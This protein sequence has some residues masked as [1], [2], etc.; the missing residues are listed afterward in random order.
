M[1][2]CCCFFCLLVCVLFLLLP[3]DRSQ[4]RTLSAGMGND[5]KM[6]KS[7]RRSPVKGHPILKKRGGAHSKG[8]VINIDARPKSQKYARGIVHNGVA[9]VISPLLDTGTQQYLIRIGDW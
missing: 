9:R 2:I 5:E 1:S 8:D 7:G 6:A 4:L 3:Q